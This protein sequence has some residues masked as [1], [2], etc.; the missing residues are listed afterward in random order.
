[1]LQPFSEAAVSISKIESRPSPGRSWAYV[2]FLDLDGHAERE[3]LRQ[4]L[5]EVAERCPLFRVLGTCRR[6]EVE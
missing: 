2:F 6:L 1:M 5:Q 4:A 3:P